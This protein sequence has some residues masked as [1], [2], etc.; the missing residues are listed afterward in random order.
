MCPCLSHGIEGFLWSLH[1]TAHGF[2]RCLQG[3][4]VCH[5]FLSGLRVLFSSGQEWRTVEGGNHACPPKAAAPLPQAYSAGEACSSFSPCH[6]HFPRRASRCV[7]ITLVTI[8]LRASL[9][10]WPCKVLWAL[11]NLLFF[12]IYK[13]DIW[14]TILSRWKKSNFF[15]MKNKLYMKVPVPQYK[16]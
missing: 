12:Y 9:F 1:P 3:Y 8:D 7:Q 14:T 11:H 13:R 4:S 6:Q 15:K 10:S 2:H 16:N 5:P